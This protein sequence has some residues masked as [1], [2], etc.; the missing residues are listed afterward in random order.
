MEKSRDGRPITE[1][2]ENESLAS[3]EEP[4]GG[5]LSPQAADVGRRR[6]L[7]IFAKLLLG[8]ALPRYT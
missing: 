7:A 6:Q 3:T 1:V 5:S 8:K 4:A 2:L